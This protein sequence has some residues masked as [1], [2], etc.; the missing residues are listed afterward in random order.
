MSASAST[1]TSPTA[2]AAS[3]A[4]DTPADV[5]A[6]HAIDW[7]QAHRTVRRLQARIV[8]ATRDGRPGK[9]KALQWLLTHSWSGRTL[10]VRRVT[11][12]QG[13][14]TPGVDGVTWDTPGQKM[15]AV[16]ALRRRGYHP[17]PLRRVYIPK[18]NG[19]GQRPLG[20]PTMHDRA[21][22]ALYLLA[23]EPIVETTGDRNS[24]GFRRARSAADAIE[25]CFKL[26]SKRSAP[27]WVL[28]GDIQ[29]CF[30]RISH[31]WLLDHVPTDRVVLRK[32]LT[33]GF[34]EQSVLYP[35]T[36]GTPQGGIISPS[37]ANAALDGLERA[38]AAALPKTTRAGQRA[39]VNLVRYAD[40]F[41]ITGSS[42]A[43]LADVVR[44]VVETFLRERG[45]AL[46]P[47]KTLI[48][49]VEAGFDFLGQHVRRYDQRLLIK[50]SKKSQA[51]LLRHVR[52]ILRTSQ[53]LPAGVVIERLN[54]VLR[55]WTN[56]HRHVC[57]AKTFDRMSHLIFGML[58]QWAARRHRD[59]TR[60]WIKDRYFHRV[61]GDAWVFTGEVIEDDDQR[62]VVHLWRPSQTRIRRHVKIRGEANPFDPAWELYF[63]TRAGVAMAEHLEH[64][65]RLLALWREQRGVCPLCGKRIDRTT[66]W[67]SHHVVWRSLGGADTNDNRVLLHP[68]CHQRLHSQGL[69]V[70]KPRPAGRAE[71]LEPDAGEL[72]RPV[73]RGG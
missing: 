32:W 42:E 10:A 62:R 68:T 52:A 50:P 43:L 13:K 46:S 71:G 24:Y 49:R 72:A 5:V 69:T 70:R 31:A 61:G 47:S 1:V 55:G 7:R 3:D 30:D 6:W 16:H 4:E 64:R 9:V 44:P 39:K 18:A 35:T 67:Q 38:L 2:C 17:R 66:G 59:Q 54:P 11:E 58:W 65:E 53:A 40:D 34:M 57:S 63:E 48:T 33:A 26:L 36:D 51:A 14:R 23:L 28:E 29:S 19:S 56:Y 22:Q 25:Q 20:I 12:N 73:L 41:I 8:K 27:R 37:L 45:L 60:F 21:M 15:S